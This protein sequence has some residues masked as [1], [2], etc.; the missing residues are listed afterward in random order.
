LEP[1]D[2]RTVSGNRAT[3]EITQEK[4]HLFAEDLLERIDTL[5]DD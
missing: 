4:Y 1:D 5:D 2:K 3:Y